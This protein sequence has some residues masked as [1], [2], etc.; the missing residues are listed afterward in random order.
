MLIGGERRGK[1]NRRSDTDGFD[2]AVGTSDAAAA[3]EADG[4]RKRGRGKKKR[5]ATKKA[6]KV[7]DLGKIR[8]WAE[9]HPRDFDGASR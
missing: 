8:S 6:D 7:V 3:A 1:R 5:E 9:R 4:C 2:E